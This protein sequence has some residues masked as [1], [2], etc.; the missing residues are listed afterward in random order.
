MKLCILTLLIYITASSC[1]G[2]YPASKVPSVVHNTIKHKFPGALDID[3]EKNADSYE[4]E[5]DLN[6]IEYTAY[7]EPAGKLIFYKHDMKVSD[8]PAAIAATINAEYAGYKIDKSEKVEK[9]NI[10]YYQVKLE[11]KQKKDLR[12]IFSADGRPQI[13]Y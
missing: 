1:G 7:V 5:F 13:N 8:F 12:L 6:G 4:A 10:V 2:D 9:D 11:S 3:W